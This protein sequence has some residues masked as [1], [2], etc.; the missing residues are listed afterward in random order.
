M[1]KIIKLF[2]IIVWVIIIL[3]FSSQNSTNSSNTSLSF[4]KS[5][6][7]FTLK[8]TNSYKDEDQ[9]FNIADKMHH[10]VRKIAHFTE[11]LI[12]SILV[13]LFLKEFKF[14]T[15]YIIL[16]SLLFCLNIAILDETY[17][18][19]ID[20]RAGQINDVLIDIFGSIIF[21]AFYKL[22]KCL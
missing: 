16:I 4:T 1:K 17:Q 9:V 19:F 2:S 12:L 22:K 14:N 20:G 10:M 11:F 5:I 15:N 8:I 18:L 21:A 6:V 7:S 3:L 13:I